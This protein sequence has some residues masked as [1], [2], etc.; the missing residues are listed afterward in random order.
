MRPLIEKTKN[1]LL[2][3]RFHTFNHQ[4]FQN[5]IQMQYHHNMQH[6]R[7]CVQLTKILTI[8]VTDF[9]IVC[10][11]KTKINKRKKQ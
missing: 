6:K 5:I 3:L 1:K 8:K 4:T 2:T 9:N 11:K 10:S 7:T